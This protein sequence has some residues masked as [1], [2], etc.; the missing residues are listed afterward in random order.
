LELTFKIGFFCLHGLTAAIV[1]VAAAVITATAAIL[2]ADSAEQL[3]GPGNNL[4]TVGCKY[5]DSAGDSSQCSKNLQN[6]LHNH[7]LLL[8]LFYLQYNQ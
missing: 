4:I 1:I 3:S 6:S 8:G 2:P 5:I 7:N